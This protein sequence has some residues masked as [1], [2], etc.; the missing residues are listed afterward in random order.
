MNRG[1]ARWGDSGA[2]NS[3]S[4]LARLNSSR[5]SCTD[6]LCRR[7]PM[8]RAGSCA[9]ESREPRQVRKKAAVSGYL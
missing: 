5:R 7:F 4:A 1:R 2:L 8:L 6:G 3:Q 9:A